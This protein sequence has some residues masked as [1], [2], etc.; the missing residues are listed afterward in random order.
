MPDIHDI[1]AGL[2]EL[3]PVLGTVTG[4]S[5]IAILGSRL[6]TLGQE[7]I[8]RRMASSGMARAQVLEDAAATYVQFRTENAELK[9]LGHEN[10]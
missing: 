9:K 4:H 3:L 1:I 7:E 10:E 8:E 5:E 2:Q 6:I